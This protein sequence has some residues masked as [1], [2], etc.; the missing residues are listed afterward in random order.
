MRIEP[1]DRDSP[2][3]MF[4]VPAVPSALPGPS[5]PPLLT[6]TLPLMVPLPP[7]VAPDATVVVPIAVLV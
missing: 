7:K 3:R 4:R 6:T 2:P 1:L 5:V